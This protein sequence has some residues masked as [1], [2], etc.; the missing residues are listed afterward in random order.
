VF[1]LEYLKVKKDSTFRIVLW[2][3]MLGMWFI[4]FLKQFDWIKGRKRSNHRRRTTLSVITYWLEWMEYQMRA[5]ILRQ[6]RF[7]GG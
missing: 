4:W 2:F 3:V 5:V 6:I 7:A 1:L